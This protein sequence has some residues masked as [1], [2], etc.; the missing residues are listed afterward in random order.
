MAEDIDIGKFFE[1]ATTN[2][3]YVNGLILHGITKEI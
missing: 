1:L 3:K 2:K